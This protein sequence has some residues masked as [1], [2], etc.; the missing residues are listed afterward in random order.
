MVE[1]LLPPEYWFFPI[2]Y[3]VQ[4]SNYIPIRTDSNTLSTP[5]FLVHNQLP[6]YRKLLPLFSAAYVKIYKSGEGNTLESQTVKAILVGNDDKSDGRLFYNPITKKFMS[7]SDYRLN[8]S[9]PSGPI[10][11]LSYQEPTTYSLYTDSVSTDAPAFDLAQTVYLSPSYN[12]HPLE[13]AIVLDVPFNYN[14]P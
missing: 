7:S 3:A 13:K 4:V 9:C 11:N 10:F 5:H 6:D 1:H 2:K 14:E 12:T 8:I